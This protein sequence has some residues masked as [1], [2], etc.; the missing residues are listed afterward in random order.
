MTGTAPRCFRIVDLKINCVYCDGCCVKNGHSHGKQRLLCKSCKRTFTSQYTYN[1]CQ[2]GINR[3]IVSL[4]K[5][6]CGVR[7]ISRLL[8]ISVVTVLRRLL[9]ISD[10]VV[11][12]SFGLNCSYEVDEQCT[13]TGYKANRQWIVY[14][15]CRESK[16]IAGFCVGSRSKDTINSVIRTLLLYDPLMICTDKL[17]LYKLLVPASLHQTQLRSTNHIERKNLTLRTHLKRLSRR[18]ICF[19]KSAAMLVACLK[20]YFWG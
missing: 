3:M 19:S 5:E 6:G 17:N 16:R 12:P 4:L 2:Q 13:Y 18:T 14:A 9:T 11:Q 8:Q 10:T 1:A 15:I 20:I 7:S